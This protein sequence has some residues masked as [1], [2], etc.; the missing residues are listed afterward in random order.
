[1]FQCWSFCALKVRHAPR[2][3]GGEDPTL[4]MPLGHVLLSLVACKRIMFRNIF[5]RAL[6][7][8]LVPDLAARP[9]CAVVASTVHPAGDQ[10][11]WPGRGT[12]L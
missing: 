8:I 2:P 10:E 4:G 3:Q 12:P 1:M 6:R 5:Q 9:N 11:V 7:A